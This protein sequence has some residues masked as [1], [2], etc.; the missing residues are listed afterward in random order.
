MNLSIK[1]FIFPVFFIILLFLCS[2]KYEKIYSYYRPY[3]TTSLK[4]LDQRELLIAAFNDTINIV[5][6]EPQLNAYYAI[7]CGEF[8][9]VQ[10]TIVQYGHVWSTTSEN[11]KIN[12]RDTTTFSKYTNKWPIDSVG[13]F[14]SRIDLYP[15]T[16]FWARSYVI[17]S[18][19]DT[20]YNQLVY[21]DTTL[22]PINQWFIASEATN[23][24]REGSCV[25][26]MKDPELNREVAYLCFGKNATQTFGD[27]W[28]FD[29]TTEVW[30]QRPGMLLSPRTE[31]VAFGMISSDQWGRKN[32]NIY[33]GTGTDITGTNIYSD[34]YEYS[35]ITYSWQR[36]I[37][38]FPFQ[39][40]SAVAFTIGDKAYV[41]TGLSIS[42]QRV[43]Y[44]FD[45]ARLD[46][47]NNPW[48]GAPS[49]GDLSEEQYTR[50][51]AVAFVI[52]DYAFIATGK[53][54][55]NNGNTI[56]HNDL[57]VFLPPHIYGAN[58]RWVRKNNL[59][60]YVG[61]KTAGVGFAVSNYG[62]VGLGE[63]ADGLQK[64][65]YRYDPYLDVWFKIADYKEGPDY[66]GQGPQ[67][68]KN[69]IGFGLNKK[70]FVGMGFRGTDVEMPYTNEMWIYRPW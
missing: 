27:L 54:V 11:P 29:P 24:E 46:N 31:A 61:G 68:T 55:D 43:F 67:A 69:G 19:G 10:D 21:V 45:K 66:D 57:W 58:A 13:K 15:E 9:H 16:I 64:D 41:G 14:N 40:M 44:M 23:F 22:A 63:N 8:A 56:Y 18:Q 59:P 6:N 30:S 62:Y 50:R 65:F 35:F 7:V 5:D 20:G 60:D 34:F 28:R 36:K 2:C 38:D 12:P 17:T 33:A 52:G 32:Y 51:D 42:D 47:L 25:F 70:G 37:N 26:T 39:L 3:Y 1:K 53:R 48:V 49:I 4:T